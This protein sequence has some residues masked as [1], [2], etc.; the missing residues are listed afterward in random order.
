MADNLKARNILIIDAAAILLFSIVLVV[1]NLYLLD[2]ANRSLGDLDTVRTRKLQLIST[3]T[4]VARERSA[5]ML[6]MYIENDFWAQDEHYRR[7]SKIAGDFIAARDRLVEKGLEPSEQRVLEEILSVVRVTEPLQ[8]DIVERIYTGQLKGVLADITG[9][10]LP[11][12]FMLLGLFEGLSNAVVENTNRARAQAN[13]D[14]RKMVAAVEAISALITLTLVVLMIWSLKKV[15]TIEQNL[16]EKA[17]RLG[18]D[19]A[20]DPL[21]GIYNRRWLQ[22]CVDRLGENRRRVEVAHALIYIDLDGFKKIND[23]YGHAVGD[24]Y[25]IAFCREVEHV[26]RHND[27][28][29][30]MGGDEFA[31]LLE[32]CRPD[33]A[34]RIARNVLDH[35]RDLVVTVEGHLFRVTCSIGVCAFTPEE[36]HYDALIRRADA[37]CYR[38]K[39]E[40]RNTVAVEWD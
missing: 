16:V 22:Y 10:D 35:V 14:F 34:A 30:R 15:G 38:A 18:L 8:Q 12:E 24:Q 20:L 23:E 6:K 27:A 21:T 9:K 37:L 25:L 2:H 39:S 19:A 32:D 4:N 7:F 17:E 11:K 29:C 40:G 36:A 3:M 5:L 26:I 33:M 31:I 1:F 28:F 13:R